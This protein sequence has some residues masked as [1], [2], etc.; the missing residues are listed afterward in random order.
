VNRAYIIFALD[1]T[2]ASLMRDYVKA[3]REAIPPGVRVLAVN[4]PEVLEGTWYGQQAVLMEF[5]SV[6]AAR[7]WYRSSSYQA[8]AELRHAAAQAK[9]AIVEG[10]DAQAF[11]DST[12]DSVADLIGDRF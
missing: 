10:I 11:T 9:V 7:Q 6:E 12:P 8:A 1:I 3:A 5:E 2:D 4:P